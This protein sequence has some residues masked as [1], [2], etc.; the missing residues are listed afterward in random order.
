MLQVKQ[1]EAGAEVDL[2]YQDDVRFLKVGTLYLVTAANDPET[3]LF[4]SKV[5]TPR[6]S[7]PRCVAKDPIYTRLADG[8]PVPTGI[9]SGM[10]GK[11]RRV[12][13]LFLK[14]LA[15]VMGGLI[16]LVLLKHLALL[17]YRFILRRGGHAPQPSPP[18]GR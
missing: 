10:K 1:G 7:D 6:A 12:P 13:L 15:A 14:P 17:A 8:Q 4:V 9:F 2:E 5:K 11:W 16:V 18:P 3:K